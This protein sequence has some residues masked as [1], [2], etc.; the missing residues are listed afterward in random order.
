MK[1]KCDYCQTTYEDT[2]P[3]CPACGA[4]NPTQKGT[5]DLTPKTIEEL[6]AR[7]TARHLPPPET[8]R[9][10]IGVDYKEPKA[11]GI[12]QDAAGDFVVY[13]NKADGSR[14]VR[15]KGR[16][17]AYAVNELYQKLKDEIVNQKSHQSSVRTGNMRHLFPFHRIGLIILVVCLASVA[18]SAVISH[19]NGRNNGYYR[20]DNTVYYCYQNDWFVFDDYD[21]SW[22]TISDYDVP[23]NMVSQGVNSDYYETR[24]WDS[25]VG[26]DDWDN[27]SFYDDYHSGSSDDSDSGY[28]WD[29]GD[30]WDSGGTDWGSDW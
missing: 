30:S 2:L 13:K 20:Y 6:K 22:Y 3:E 11:F 5:S 26:A 9:F 23:G 12:Y 4:P 28:D 21:D 25:S 24:S 14:A 16:N 19:V 7:Y 15:Y 1:I 18:I 10:F 8:T 17:E 27:S 29:S